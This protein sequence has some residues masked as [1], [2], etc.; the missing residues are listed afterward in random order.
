MSGV[1]FIT[2]HVKP[3]SS[4]KPSSTILNITRQF[5]NTTVSKFRISNYNYTNNQQFF[6]LKKALLFSGVFISATTILTPYLYQ[7]PPFNHFKKNP[8]HFVYGLIAINLAVFLAWRIPKFWRVLHRYALLQKDRQFNS[9][10]IIGSAFSQQEVWHLAMN[11][12]ALYSFGVSLAQVVG[13]ENFTI[14]YLNGA[15]L[16]SLGSLVY[17]LLMRLPLV[18][19][20]LGASGALFAVFGCFANL[21]PMAK[22]MI[23]FF[24]IPGGAQVAFLGAMIWNIAGCVMRWGSFD[25]AA[26]FVGGCFGGLFGW[27]LKEKAERERERRWSGRLW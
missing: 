10:Q 16:S 22:I 11:M 7:I 5:H 24:P 1:K 21:F 14:L 15:V 12:L 23:L 8:S 4:F 20:S 25:Y 18:G 9:L 3:N 17:P 2:N 6:N 26:H 13:I 27:Y 19:A